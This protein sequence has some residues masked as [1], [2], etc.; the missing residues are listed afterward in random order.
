MPGLLA[1]LALASSAA[2]QP[3]GLD[4]PTPVGPFLDDALPHRA[5]NDPAT[6]SWDVVEAFPNLPLQDTLVIV[7]HPVS[8][9]LVV[10]SRDGHIQSFANDPQASALQPFLDLRDRVAVVWDGGFL[11]LAFHPEFGVPGSPFRGQVFVY[12]SSA[13]PLNAARDA[14][15]LAACDPDYPRDSTGGFFGAYLRLSRFTVADGASQADPASERVL[16]NIRLVNGSHRGGGMVFGDDGHLYLMIGDQ[17]NYTTAQDIVNNL[18]GGSHRLAVDVTEHG[19]GTWSCPAGSHLPR[20]IYDTPDEISG[21]L[22]CIPDDNP[23]LDP[24]GGNFEEY[25]SLGHRNPHR[26]AKDPATGRLWSGEVGEAKREEINVIA[27]GNNYGWPFREGTI[28]GPDSPP[29]N[30][31]GTLTDPVIDFTRSEAKTIIG[32]YVY[33]G[34]RFPELVGM[35][36]AG[37]YSTRNLWAIEYDSVTGLAQKIP[38]TQFPGGLGTWGQDLAGE[39]YLGDVTQNVPLYTLARLGN[40]IPDPP[41]LLS[42]LGAFDDLAALDPADGFVPYDLVQPFWSD[43]ALKRRW[44]ALP[45]DGSH[46][47]PAEQIAWSENGNWSFPAGTVLMKHFELG[48][49][50]TDPAQT[51][52]LE[53]R[54]LVFGDDGRPYGLTYRWLPDQSDAQLLTAGETGDY[55]VQTAAGGVRTQTWTFPSRSQCLTCHN[56]AA[57]GALG[58]RTRQ[59]NRT[60]TYP[61]TGRADNQLRTWSHLGMFDTPLPEADIP[62]YLTGH[63]LGDVT[64]SL[65]DRAR[66]YLDV[67]CAYCHRPGT[68]VRTIFDLR[69]TSP[70]ANQGIVWASPI[71][72][73]GIPGASLVAPGSPLQSVLW[74]RLAAVDGTAMP[75]LAKSLAEAPAVEVVSE[76]IERIDPGFPQGGVSYEYYETNQLAALPDFDSLTPVR[77][78]SAATFDISPRDQDDDFAFRFTGWIYVDV[79]GSYTFYTSSDD[80]S[81]LFIDGALVVDNDGLHATRERSGGVSLAAGYH[82]ITVTFFE[83]AGQQVLVTSWAGPGFAQQPIPASRLFRAIPGPLVNAAP[84]LADL[85]DQANRVDRSLALSLDASDADGDALHYAA[86]GL[87]PGL[88]LDPDTGMI[89]GTPTQAGVWD[90]TVSVSDGPEVDVASFPWLIFQRP[91]CGLGFELALVLAPLAAWWRRRRAPRAR[92]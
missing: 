10:G 31:L 37:D 65:E 75:P 84:D 88:A 87:P 43:A 11:G 68:A 32:G 17:F 15:D 57:G 89:A 55:D 58:P 29:A 14:V 40:P 61:S 38:L 66:S 4:A 6:S 24:A 80:G 1:A 56:T 54:F 35:Y 70:L 83:R 30:I 81:Q 9:D 36:L 86:S 53:T 59:L 90:V 64:A 92:A 47:T 77:T 51:V 7:P 22:Y 28:A 19:D 2:A 69:L 27:Q 3:H 20:R 45:N 49:D 82:D 60:L 23:W 21:Q 5:P 42:Q 50:E 48:T 25:F 91:A 18:E 34:S 78:G 26:L 74:H 52:R 39:V 41:A 85:P 72:D 67:N 73:L 13:C 12:Y 16:L 71:D 76:W 44:I 33:R 62:G 46:D 79:A 63:A 8:G